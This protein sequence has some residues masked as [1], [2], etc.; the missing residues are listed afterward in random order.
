[1]V[2]RDHR[3]LVDLLNQAH[4]C[5]G[6]AEEAVTLGSVLNALVDY[7]EY[8]FAR[9]ER[10]MQVAR[11]PELPAHRELHQRLAQ[12]ARD[13]RTR[14]AAAPD[15]LNARDVMEF[16]RTWLIDHILKQDFRYRPA[17]MAEPEAVRVAS[18]IPFDGARLASP[19]APVAANQDDPDLPDPVDFRS[20]SVLVVDDNP[21]FQII[22]RTI[23]KGLGCPSITLA[24]NGH[25][26]LAALETAAPALVL[27]DWRMEG[28]DGLAFVR[29]A[30]RQGVSAPIVM[31]S[32]YSEPGFDG[33]ARE[34]GVDAF[35]EKPITARNLVDTVSRAMGQG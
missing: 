31:I 15:S 4:D 24:D 23:L 8:H 11:Y 27:V 16:L 34:A 14:Y 12:Q 5:I 2:D 22:L 20:L 7:T 3:V 26:G 32:G 6:V 33:T 9:E 29:E 28:M 35:L 13:F 1:M 18:A 19:A 10:L 25:E 17:V 30:R 21:N